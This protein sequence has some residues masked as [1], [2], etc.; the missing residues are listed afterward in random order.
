MFSTELIGNG[1][2]AFKKRVFKRGIGTF[3]AVGAPIL[4]SA[5]PIPSL[6]GSKTAATAPRLKKVYK[7]NSKAN[8][9]TV[10]QVAA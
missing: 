5:W 9:I 7:S 3:G 2:A 6:S 10:S 8:P 1:T 4:R